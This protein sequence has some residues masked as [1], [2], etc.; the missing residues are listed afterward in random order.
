VL[1]VNHT[2]T[3]ERGSKRFSFSAFSLCRNE[4]GCLRGE[5]FDV[6]VDIRRDSSTFL[7]WHSE[8]LLKKILSLFIPEGFAHGFQALA[9]DCEFIYF[10]S[11]S[12]Q[13]S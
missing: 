8:L 13:S 12:Y 6:A 2:L 1:Q 7:Q 11:E 5:V 4:I 3:K 9:D 10:H